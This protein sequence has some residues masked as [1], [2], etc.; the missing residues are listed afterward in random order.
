MSEPLIS[1]IIPCYKQGQYLSQALSSVV[2][3]TYPNWECII[4]ND[5]SPDNTEE[6]ALEW[7]QKDNRIHYIKKANGG[8]SSARNEGIAA[9]KGEYIQLL[10]ADD[11]IDKDKLFLHVSSIVNDNIAPNVITY[12][13]AR[14]FLD[15]PDELTI[16][17]DD[18]FPQVEL[19]LYD[20]CEDHVKMVFG[21]N[22]VVVS[23]PLYPKKLFSDVGLYD[24]K[25]KSLE[26]WDM[27]IR[28]ILAKYKFHKLSYQ[29]HAL[30]LIRVSSNSMMANKAVLN[31][32]WEM[33][34]AKHR[35]SDVYKR[36]PS[37][38][39]NEVA[40]VPRP[41]LIKKAVWYLIPPVIIM[42]YKKIKQK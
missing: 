24:E 41:G 8:L 15:K 16:F 33:L 21:R 18:F 32:A 14:Y 3:Q 42:A 36:W 17:R 19:T 27:N 1:I 9:A 10:D 20:S 2:N 29:P 4:I 13:S 25:F 30:T 34:Y 22:I 40:A 12:S 39:D 11:L 5:G 35:G 23:A 26:D 31:T 38:D 28:A 37:K 7:K 6:V